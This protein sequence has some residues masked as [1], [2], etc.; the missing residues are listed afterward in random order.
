M[1]PKF[2]KIDPR[3]WHDEK[4]QT[5]DPKQKLLALYLLTG[6]DVNRI[7]IYR[8]SP[9]KASEELKIDRIDTVCHTV[10]HTLSWGYSN[11]Q[12]LVYFPTWWKYNKPDNE[13]AFEGYLKDVHDLPTDPL[14]SLF[15]HNEKYLEEKHI[16]ILSRYRLDTVYH[17]VSPLEKEKE[18]E[19]EKDI[20]LVAGATEGGAVEVKK[21]EIPKSALAAAWLSAW[22]TNR[23]P[24]PKILNVADTRLVHAL[25][26]LNSPTLQAIGYRVPD[27]YAGLIQWLAGHDFYSGG[28]NRGWKAN[29]DFLVASDGAVTKLHERRENESGDG[30]EQLT[31]D[32]ATLEL[33]RK[34]S[35]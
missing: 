29:F 15:L 21:P 5:L 24:L 1:A 2:R 31:D 13:K 22:N 27:D 18:L 14:I 4:V 16:P 7:G 20:S 34:V 35:Q 28:G 12:K 8:W 26:R 33:L 6:P 10:C 25:A 32:A 3:F 17:T 9:A 23:G 11:A 19:K 30:A